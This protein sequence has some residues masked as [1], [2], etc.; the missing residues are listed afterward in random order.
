MKRERYPDVTDTTPHV[1]SIELVDPLRLAVVADTHSLMH[2]NTLGCLRAE[3]P[4]AIL[5]AGDIGDLTVL[6]ELRSVAPVHFVRGNIDERRPDHPDILLVDLMQAGERALRALVFHIAV[7]GPKLRA[8]AKRVA[9]RHEASL[10]ICGHSHVP[11][12][13]RD[14]G[15]GVFN[16]GSCGPRR[17]TLPIVFGVIEIAALRMTMRHVD[18]TTGRTWLPG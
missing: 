1:V 3:R 15:L 16:P 2:P 13:G 9:Q 5:H 17:F 12:L 8:D 14:G 7:N 4:H 18:V 10:V 11:F 6:D